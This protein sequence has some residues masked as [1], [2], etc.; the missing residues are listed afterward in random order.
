MV[1]KEAQLKSG[2]ESSFFLFLNILLFLCL[3][4]DYQDSSERLRH[5]KI[6]SFEMNMNYSSLPKLGIQASFF[7]CRIE[8]KAIV[9]VMC[10]N[11]MRIL[12]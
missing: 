5:K 8:F 3:D 9:M 11:Y 1:G 4:W 6:I 12:T 2:S 10:H 7:C